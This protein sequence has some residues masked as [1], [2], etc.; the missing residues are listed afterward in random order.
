MENKK[1]SNNPKSTTKRETRAKRKLRMK[2]SETWTDKIRGTQYKAYNWREPIRAMWWNVK[3]MAHIGARQKIV[4]TMNTDSI[5][6]MFIMETQIDANAIEIHD[7]YTFIFSTI[8]T[9]DMKKK[10]EAAREE[11]IKQRKKGPLTQVERE[12]DQKQWGEISMMAKEKIGMAIIYNERVARARIDCIQH[13]NRCMS[14]VLGMGNNMTLTLTSIHMDHANAT[15]N[16]KAQKYKLLKDIDDKY[17]KA[18]NIHVIGGDFNARIIETA[19]AEQN[20]IGR[21][22]YN[23]DK[24]T[25]DI[26]SKGQ[27]ENRELFVDY[28][29]ERN[30]SVTN[31]WFDKKDI[32]LVT[33]RCPGEPKFDSKKSNSTRFAQL[34]HILCHQ[35][36]K[37]GVKNVEAI[38][39]M[40]FESDHQGLLAT[41]AFKLKNMKKKTKP[42]NNA[43]YRKP[44]EETMKEYNKKIIKWVEYI[45][46][47]DTD[48]IISFAEWQEILLETAELC[49]DK[50]PKEQK[51]E[52][53]S[54]E[55]WE[56][57]EKKKRVKSE[58]N[59]RETEELEKSIRKR[60]R[61]EKLQDRLDKL[62]E[63]DEQGYKWTEL[64]TMKKTYVPKN[65]KFKDKEGNK[66]PAEKFP[67]KAAEYLSEVQWK[68]P[69]DPPPTKINPP[70]YIEDNA[71][72]IK[73]DKFH[74]KELNLVCSLLKRN[75][76]P[77]PDKVKAELIIWT[78]DK[79]REHLLKTINHTVEEGVWEDTLNLARVASIYKKG[80]STNLANYR[81]ISLLQ[82]FYKLIAALVKERLAAAIDSK[83]TKTQYGFR[84]GKSTSHAIYLARRLLD[85]AE[86]EGSNLSLILLDWEKAFDKID[87]SRMIEALERLGVKGMILNTIK[88]MYVNPKFKVAAG[89]N[90]SEY[91]SQRAGIRQG[92]HLSPYL[93]V[94]VMTVIFKDIRQKLNTPKQI[95]PIDHVKFAE[96]LYADD[97]LVFGTHTKH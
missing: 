94:L 41:L 43:A 88:M 59:L 21:Y 56:L 50:I 86:V 65:C 70:Q 14:I 37:N 80:D 39:K 52:Y 17:G 2:E 97:T 82:V 12:E 36:W 53:I 16:V 61:A 89:D 19:P 15:S 57:M 18:P 78:S 67:E 48:R 45:Q 69:T 11:Y 93:F 60:L 42:K 6:I 81:P 49:L 1:K 22:V 75:K 51:K 29:M 92:C 26:L 23:P 32:E 20:N 7:G 10:K 77:G 30:M 54:K 68:E 47:S 25:L 83:I 27:I 76:A 87:Q 58:G 84:K 90:E 96:I 72:E 33:Y 73:N 4:H 63:M 95:E 71:P 91:Y 9:E 38:S 3:G 28:C 46:E 64:K 13:D 62:E 5:D 44:D 85:I 40:P 8:V 55:T 24:E 35:K 66:I 34:D 31:T 79:V 74:I